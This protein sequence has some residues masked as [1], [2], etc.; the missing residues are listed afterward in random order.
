MPYCTMIVCH[1]LIV[2]VHDHGTSTLSLFYSFSCSNPLCSDAVTEYPSPWRM[3][4]LRQYYAEC[5]EFHQARL[6][7]C[8]WAL[9]VYIDS[10]ALV[11][12]YYM[13]Y[14]VLWVCLWWKGR[15]EGLGCLVDWLLNT[16]RS[17]TA[18][19]VTMDS[20]RLSRASLLSAIAVL[21]AGIVTVINRCL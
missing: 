10:K 13:S 1:T 5:C 21:R 6:D 19:A 4:S 8:C 9:L 7:C 11:L 20:K 15:V 17:P 3:D 16:V 14:W 18:L 12:I 2:Y